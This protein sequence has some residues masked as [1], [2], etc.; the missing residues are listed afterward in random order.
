M[1]SDIECVIEEIDDSSGEGGLEST[2]S[3]HA[4]IL[5]HNR[6]WQSVCSCTENL[7]VTA[8]GGSASGATCRSGTNNTGDLSSSVLVCRS[9]SSISRKRPLRPLLLLPSGSN[10]ERAAGYTAAVD[11]GDS[12]SENGNVDT[13]PVGTT[14]N[15]LAQSHA[16]ASP[17]LPR[18]PRSQP[19]APFDIASTN[20]HLEKF[21]Q[22]QK[23]AFER[24]QQVSM[25]RLQLENTMDEERGNCSGSHVQLDRSGAPAVCL[26]PPPS[27]P[28]LHESSSPGTVD[29]SVTG[30]AG[31][32]GGTARTVREETLPQ[33]CPATATVAAVVVAARASATA[34][35]SAVACASASPAEKGPCAAPAATFDSSRTFEEALVDVEGTTVHDES[36]AG[37]T[38]V[39]IAFAAASSKFFANEYTMVLQ[40]LVDELGTMGTRRTS[41]AET[42]AAIMREMAELIS[43]NAPVDQVRQKKAA[44]VYDRTRAET[45]EEG[46]HHDEAGV[47]SSA[48]HVSPRA[49]TATF[50]SMDVFGATSS[51]TTADAV[52][53][54]IVTKERVL[55]NPATAATT[56]VAAVAA[57]AVGS[58]ASQDGGASRVANG[59]ST[60]YTE[61]TGQAGSENHSGKSKGK[62][63]ARATAATGDGPGKGTV[64][65]MN[66]S[67]A[68]STSFSAAAAAAG[69]R[70]GASRSAEVCPGVASAPDTL[71]SENSPLD[72][73]LA[74]SALGEIGCIASYRRVIDDFV[75]QLKRAE[76]AGHA[77]RQAKVNSIM[78]EL[79][80][81]MCHGASPDEVT[82]RKDEWLAERGVLIAHAA[83]SHREPR[84]WEEDQVREGSRG[85][86]S[87]APAQ[88]EEVE[89]I[90]QPRGDR[91]RIVRS[92]AQNR[93]DGAGQLNFRVIQ[94][95][96]PWR[97]RQGAYVV[98]MVPGDEVG[99]LKS[100]QV[101]NF[102]W[103]LRPLFMVGPRLWS[104]VVYG[105]K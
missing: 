29:E 65:N 52:A 6:L 46:E 14:D 63:K 30:G 50:P 80:V 8:G 84:W 81:R 53:A 34:T 85:G 92:S 67:A 10:A 20:K 18:P 89:V 48:P 19:E 76:A 39:E 75:D 100:T 36:G 35:T 59:Q 22:A 44:Y 69:D 33:V 57:A 62:G 91:E 54:V 88:G 64:T 58:I 68:T 16:R 26:A 83:K 94:K 87:A 60:S 23:Q 101:T 31:A 93:D 99:T 5:T 11:E 86:A 49:T 41:S 37:M 95:A 24:L 96:S 104:I 27:P 105:C 42:D 70:A 72:Y 4:P 66:A 73:V 55:T 45:Y 74:T 9:S 98:L 47:A 28:P 79:G 90:M 1:D 77:F 2:C 25:K 78:A 13:A 40:E 51:S 17:I 12:R 21:C 32:D 15:R 102:V 61:V 56:A 97:D 38:P 82:K 103:P 7:A 3:Q 43:T 71:S